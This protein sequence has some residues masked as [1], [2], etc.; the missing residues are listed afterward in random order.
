VVAQYKNLASRNYIVTAIDDK[1]CFKDFNTFVPQPDQLIITT[2]IVHNDCI[3]LDT[4]GKIVALVS[5]GTLPYQYR[6][7]YD[8]VERSIISGLENGFYSLKVKDA[9]DCEDS[10]ISEVQYDNCCTP[11]IPNAFTPNNDGKNDVFR[12]LYKGDIVLKEFSIYNRY[13]Q[14]IFTTNNINDVWDGRF[15]GRDE[16]LGVYYYLVKIICGNLKNKEVLL[17]GDVTLIR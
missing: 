12:I 9:N 4:N 1:N 6:W 17:K 5:G 15:N 14:Q 16:D 3:G 8:N 7:S 11:S 13:G 2:E 10:L